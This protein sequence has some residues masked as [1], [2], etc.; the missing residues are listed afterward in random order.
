MLR[1]SESDLVRGAV[2]RAPVSRAVVARYVAGETVAEAVDTT[3]ELRT[4]NR[5]ATIPS[6]PR[7]HV[8]P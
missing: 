4:T 7:C 1:L 8:S 3:A 5:L 6:T 2:V